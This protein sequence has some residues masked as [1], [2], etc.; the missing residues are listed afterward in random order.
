M[1][2]GDDDRLYGRRVI[3]VDAFAP[4]PSVRADLGQPLPFADGVFDG[5]VCTEVLEHVPDP[6]FL[7]R[8]LARVVRP[9][10]LAIVTV[11]FVFRYHPDPDDFVRFTPMGL[12]RELR[13]A[14]FDAELVGGVGGRIAALLLLLEGIHISIKLFVRT[15]VLAWTAMT[16]SHRIARLEPWSD[17][18]SHAVAVVRRRAI[19]GA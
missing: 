19:D 11:P 17:W 4:R 18:A 3:R 2:A 6:G 10:A 7:L 16:P 8:E 9:G 14:G 13:A 12:G 15:L 1:G 5:A